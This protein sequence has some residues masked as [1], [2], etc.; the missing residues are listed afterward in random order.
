VPWSTSLRQDPVEDV[1][2]ATSD[3][4]ARYETVIAEDL[5]VAGMT[6]NRRLARAIADAGFGA[7][8][9]MFGYKTQWNGGRLILA[10]RW[11]P[12]SKTCSGCGAVK[13]TLA[14]SERTYCC[15]T[16]GLVLDREV[17]AARNLLQLAPSGAESINACGGTVRPGTAGHD[18]VNQEPGPAPAGKT[19]TA[20]EQPLAAGHELTLTDPATA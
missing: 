11:Y 6:H 4:A 13:A 16:C 18:P 2:K 17:N 19:G 20:S 10:G 15:D 9:R 3:L 8:V 1:G 5:N 14:L 7:A 12:S